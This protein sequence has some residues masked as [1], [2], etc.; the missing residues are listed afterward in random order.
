MTPSMVVVMLTLFMGIQPVTTDLYLPGLPTLQR[1]LGGGVAGAQ[2]TLSVLI[3]CF[4]VG[5]LV[6]G[7][8]A[9]RFGRRP[10]LLAGV[11][12]Y[13]LAA[14]GGATAPSIGMLV[15]WRALQGAAMAAA[16][17]C[18]RSV[19]RDLFVPAEGARVLSRALSGLGVIAMLSPVF[20]GLAV[21][22]LGWRAA[23]VMPA[24]F[25]AA[26]LALVAT[27]FEETTPL[28]NPLATRPGTLLANWRAVL[29]NPTF[30]AWATL[31]AFTYGGLFFML[32]GSSF[33]FIERLGTPRAAYG[34]MLG[35]M[36]VAYVA[37]TVLCRRLLPRFGLRGTVARGAWFSL[38]GGVSM[39]ALDLAGVASVWAILLPQYVFAIGHGIHQPCGQ[40]GAVGPFPERAGTAASLSGFVM[41]AAALGVGLWVGHA[42]TAASSL[43]VT[44]GIGAFSIGLAA[45]AWTWVQRDGE[46][47]ASPQPAPRAA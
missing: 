47:A 39:A 21:E 14:L 31:S 46:P 7:P 23:L 10:V 3:I 9:D 13:T 15:A 1:E 29:A 42:L 26:T 6:C 41:T 37:G 12:L 43:P 30:R 24:L 32:A 36:S 44:L 5:Q 8:L 18:G 27:R 38:A 11:G 35:T 33:I 25:G 20:G 40:A 2:L 4:G 28:K 17:T 45:V 34:V 16:V 22:T 19:I